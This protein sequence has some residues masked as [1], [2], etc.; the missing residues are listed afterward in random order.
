MAFFSE[1]RQSRLR[2]TF[3]IVND[4]NEQIAYLRSSVIGLLVR[5]CTR[6][7][8]EHEQEI[9]AGT[10]EGALIKHIAE[11]PAA[12]Y[13]HCAE[14]SLKRIYRS[15]DVLD[16][17]LAGFRIIST[18]LELMVDAVT[19]PGKEKA[20]S[21]LLTNR[22]SDQYNIKSPVLYEMCIRDRDYTGISPSLFQRR[23]PLSGLY[24]CIVRHCCKWYWGFRASVYIPLS[25]RY[26]D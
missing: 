9:L 18:L 12:A 11:G 2:S 3:Q 8:L 5:E 26:A 7:F 25:N 1:D 6:V 14:I 17:E 15:Q 24:I 19:L 10:F 21:E 16:I 13:N 4:I 22:V 23:F 20:Y